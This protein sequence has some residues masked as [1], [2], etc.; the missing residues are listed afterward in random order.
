MDAGSNQLRS[1]IMYG[2]RL[3]P[4]KKTKNV[5]LDVFGG[6]LLIRA[7]LAEFVNTI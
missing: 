1:D 4:V 5:S 2:A 3:H 7:D 6:R